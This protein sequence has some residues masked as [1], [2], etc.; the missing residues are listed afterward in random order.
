M[1]QNSN[2]Y[3][4]YN[5]LCQL[6]DLFMAS[7]DKGVIYVDLRKQNTFWVLIQEG[8]LSPDSLL[9]KRS[10]FLLKKVIRASVLSKSGSGF[11]EKEGWTTYFRWSGNSEHCQ[12]LWDTF[13]LIFETLDEFT[14]HLIKP[15]WTQLQLLFP[16]ADRTDDDA[17]IHFSWVDLLCRKA[18]LLHPNLSV[19][20]SL[21]FDLLS[22]FA[23]NETIV[24]TLPSNFVLSTLFEVLDNPTIYRPY[25]LCMLCFNW[26]S[27]Q[28][29]F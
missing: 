28:F 8:L 25:L 15:V 13:I 19:Q 22:I 17:E 11:G 16:P 9:R 7:D 12:K 23:S 5:L 24:R 14:L 4:V 3:S 18:L 20:K 1:A 26:N 2:K 29:R 27:L 10:M 6:C 21:T